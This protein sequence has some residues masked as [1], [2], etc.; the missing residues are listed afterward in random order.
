MGTAAGSIV[1]E[2]EREVDRLFVAPGGDGR[3]LGSGGSG[4]GGSGSGADGVELNDGPIVGEEVALVPLL[5]VGLLESWREV[6]AVTETVLVDDC[7]TEGVA[8]LDTVR[9]GVNGAVWLGVRLGEDVGMAVGVDGKSLITSMGT[10]TEMS[11]QTFKT[12]KIKSTSPGGPSTTRDVN[13]IDELT[14]LEGPP[15]STGLDK[16]DD[17][18]ITSTEPTPNVANSSSTEKSSFAITVSSS[19]ISW[20]EIGSSKTT[21]SVIDE[22]MVGPLYNVVATKPLGSSG[23]K[24]G[25]EGMLSSMLPPA[26]MCTSA[27][28]GEPERELTKKATEPGLFSSM[29][30]R[31]MPPER[32]TSTLADVTWQIAPALVPATVSVI[33]AA[34]T[35]MSEESPS[36]KKMGALFPRTEPSVI[37]NSMRALEELVNRSTQS[38][39]IKSSGIPASACQLRRRSHMERVV[40]PKETTC[41]PDSPSKQRSKL[42]SLN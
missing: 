24:R 35:L 20:K 30:F 15:P 6:D 5:G 41:T 25:R 31:Q 12:R 32:V 10:V 23:G 8:E 2:G 16:D 11:L 28:T 22:S 1:R 33:S 21:A 17:S 7:D 42:L 19:E 4:V 38:L 29:K 18:T 9:E 39:S 14:K 26:T 40:K 37:S 13:R 27:S 34:S 3:G 36:A